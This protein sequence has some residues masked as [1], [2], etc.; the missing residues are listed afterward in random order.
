VK[1]IGLRRERTR[2]EAGFLLGLRAGA[3]SS[4][5]VSNHLPDR[6]HHFRG[7]HAFFHDRFPPGCSSFAT[8]RMSAEPSSSVMSFLIGCQTKVRSPTTWPRDD[9]RRWRSQNFRGSRRRS[10]N[11]D[12]HGILQITCLARPEKDLRRH[13]LAAQRGSA[14]PKKTKKPSGRNRLGNLSS[15][16]SRTSR[17]TLRMPCFSAVQ[18]TIANLIRPAAV[19]RGER[20]TRM[21]G[22]TLRHNLRRRT[23]SPERD[24][25]PPA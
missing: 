6:A 25:L 9:S 10:V 21:S 23:T 22:S 2:S 12:R 11:Q 4:S 7:R 16:N 17:M 5:G 13:C 18:E 24:R 3:A 15:A 8:V 19:E 14:C 1:K 20:R